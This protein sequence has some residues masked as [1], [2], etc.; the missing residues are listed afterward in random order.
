MNKCNKLH[1]IKTCKQLIISFPSV[2]FVHTNSRR[3][4]QVKMAVTMTNVHPW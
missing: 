3:A 1:R 2:T 4:W